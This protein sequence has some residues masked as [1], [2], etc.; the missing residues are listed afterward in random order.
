MYEIYSDYRNS[1]KVNYNRWSKHAAVDALVSELVSGIENRKKAIYFNNMKVLILDLY[2]SFLT[3]PEQYISYHRRS[4]H[5]VGIRDKYA[6]GDKY[7][8]NPHI[9]FDGFVE[10]VDH[11]HDNGY[12]VNSKGGNFYNEELGEY[13]FLSRMRATH[14]LVELWERYG[15]K[16]NM[17]GRFREDEVIIQKDFETE[18]IVNKGKPNER[19]V[20]KRE[21]FNYKDNPYVK[22]MRKRVMAYNT[23]LEHIHIDCDAACMT[24]DDKA[25]IIEKL[26]G[27]NKKMKPEIRIKLLNK[28]VYRVF[29]NRSWEQGGRFYGA[30]WIGCPSELRK[31]ITLNGK[32]TVELDYSGIHI[33]LLYAKIGINYA[34]KREDPYALDDGTNTRDLN[35]LIL[36][37]AINAK[38]EPLARSSVFD[39]LRTDNKL[40]EYNISNHEPIARKIRLLKEKHAPIA[41]L[42]TSGEGIKLQYLDS[43]IVDSLIQFAVKH[44]I[45][46]LTIHDSVVCQKE[47]A[48][49]I[50][51][52]MWTYFVELLKSKFNIVVKYHRHSPLATNSIITLNKLANASY[53]KPAYLGCIKNT[54]GVRLPEIY[55]K[56]VRYWLKADDV[57]NIKEDAR[58]NEC[59]KECEH[60]RRLSRYLSRGR[61]YLGTIKVW[62]TTEGT[63]YRLLVSR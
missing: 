60:S 6:N 44:N 48:A 5:Y 42:I 59:S 47:Y 28:R 13:G 11:L 35:K 37:T 24:E 20:K 33:H 61:C 43:C 40:Y 27:Y 18:K 38:T 26:K 8:D 46:I 14:K 16:A 54:K 56:T 39:Q 49:L 62:L 29:N 19:K 32:P 21:R 31:Y 12:I 30:W 10:S 36:L 45:P 4:N 63:E 51:G 15:V 34:S 2:H 17:I 58:Q 22:S 25:K 3:D 57:I 23:F 1:R 53:R 9:S 52:K 55:S 7:T 50:K 41:H